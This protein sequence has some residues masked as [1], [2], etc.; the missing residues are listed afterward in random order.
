MLKDALVHVRKTGY[1][2]AGKVVA[3]LSSREI[4]TKLEA[5]TRQRLQRRWLMQKGYV[6][7]QTC[8]EWLEDQ[9]ND[10]FD[11]GAPDERLKLTKAEEK[12]AM[13][14]AKELQRSSS[15]GDGASAAAASAKGAVSEA[16]QKKKAANSARSAVY[17]ATDTGS[18]TGFG[19][20][21]SA[22]GSSPPRIVGGTGNKVACKRSV[23]L[24]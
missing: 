1:D 11:R 7:P 4:K 2:R 16:K 12:A 22:A 13:L 8:S 21:T 15:T 19:S 20:D 18:D 14:K 23:D 3:L 9:W 10:V 6:V 17:P 5:A 24:V